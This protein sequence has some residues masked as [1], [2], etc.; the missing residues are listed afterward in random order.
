MDDT[1]EL[2][3]EEAEDHMEEEVEMIVD[4][5]R[6]DARKDK[7]ESEEISR[8]TAEEEEETEMILDEE[9]TASE[10]KVES[11]KSK[12]EEEVLQFEVPNYPG[13]LLISPEAQ[14]GSKRLKGLF[15]NYITIGQFILPLFRNFPNISSKNNSDDHYPWKSQ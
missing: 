14:R 15:D 3:G 13:F 9:E 11:E 8:E 4:E 1:V 2:L 10:N 5:A 7:V 6:V 12:H